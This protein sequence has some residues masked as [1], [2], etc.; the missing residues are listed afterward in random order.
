[1]A[2]E[3]GTRLGHYDVTALIGEGGMGQVYQAT[4]TKL[5]RDVALKVLPQAFTDDPE[6]GGAPVTLADVEANPYGASWGTDDM[7]LYGQPEGIMQV[8]GTGGTP[9]LLI[10]TED[11]ER[12]HGPQMLPGGEWV[13]VTVRAADSEFW[14]EAEIVAQ[15]VTTGERTVLVNGGRDGRYL[16]TGHLVYSTNNVLFA[17]PFDVDSREVTGGPVPLVEGVQEALGNGGAAQFSVS[18]SG[19]LVYRPGS[20]GSGGVVTL[21]WVD[22]EGNDESLSAEPRTYSNPRVSPDGTRVAVDIADGDNTDV[23]IWDLE[24]ET[25]TQFT[26]NE[27]FDGFPLWTLDSA[28]VVFQSQREGGGLFWKSA[29]GTGQIEQLL[30]NPNG[31]RPY[32]WSADGGLILRPGAWRHRSTHDGGRAH[33]RDAARHRSYRSGP[34]G[35]PGRPLA[36]LRLQRDGHSARLRQAVCQHRR[37][38]V[39]GIARFRSEPRMVAGRTSAVLSR[40]AKHRHDGGA[41]RN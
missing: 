25:P 40:H 20:S 4:D 29:D 16:P 6:G 33:H 10:P 34:G 11:G 41:G 9:E 14:D 12:V 5:H 36:G 37:R 23:W 35:V 38:P 18:D 17:V 2:L 7:I 21:V 24:R 3:V 28:R 30:E 27:G 22:R 39:A 32:G 13:L 15:S 19:S 1:M 8:P 26:F 31:P